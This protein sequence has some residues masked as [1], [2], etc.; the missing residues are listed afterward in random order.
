[1]FYD[2]SRAFTFC[3]SQDRK[4]RFNPISALIA[5]DIANQ[6][7]IAGA[8]SIGLITPYS[9]QARLLHR[10]LR[11]TGQKNVKAATV[12]RF[13]GSEQDVIIFD[14]VDSYQKKDASKLLRGGSQSTAARLTNVA[15]SRAKGKFIGLFNDDFLK[16]KLDSFNIFRT[17]INRLRARAEVIPLS[18][19]GV[20]DIKAWNFTLPN[21]T[22][23]PNANAAQQQIQT[24]LDTAQKSVA[25]DWPTRLTPS[26]H[27]R[28]NPKQGHQLIVRGPEAEAIAQSTPNRR[29]W[30]RDSFCMMGLVG[31]DAQSLWIYTSPTANA[32][33]FRIAL[34]ETVK[35]LYDFFELTPSD[36]GVIP[37]PDKAPFG[38]CEKCN[39]PLWPQPGKY[40][41]RISCVKH[42][43]QGRNFTPQDATDFAQITKKDC[44]KCRSS[45]RGAKSNTNGKVYLR[46]SYSNCNGTISLSDII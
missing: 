28:L 29:V 14:S 27:F 19:T 41:P 35:L 17:F 16:A 21:V 36:A 34:P 10:I 45:L 23:F 7:Q 18:F 26:Q 39:Q 40:E 12:H 1:M 15:V 2:L 24:E 9:A 20:S 6:A 44:H 31:I 22:A 25:I 32:P 33:V 30:H 5:A 4:S 3:F 11:E 13:Q 8:E 42:P 46:C 37:K 38:T 43:E